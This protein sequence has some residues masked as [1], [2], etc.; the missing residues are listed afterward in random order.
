MQSKILLN[1]VKMKDAF[2]E[3]NVLIYKYLLLATIKTST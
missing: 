2:V 3:R 1:V